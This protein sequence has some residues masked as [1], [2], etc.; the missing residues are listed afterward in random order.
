[1]GMSAGTAT[2]LEVDPRLVVS[3]QTGNLVFLDL[4]LNA[5]YP[6]PPNHELIKAALRA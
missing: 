3:D 1:M 5:K 6:Q 4:A 2:Q